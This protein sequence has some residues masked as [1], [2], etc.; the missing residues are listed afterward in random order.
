MKNCELIVIYSTYSCEKSAQKMA[1]LLLEKKLIAYANIIPGGSSLYMWE[2]KLCNE[3]ECFMLCK[4]TGN[5][6]SQVEKA[7][8][9]NHSYETP[10]IYALPTTDASQDYLDFVK[11]SLSK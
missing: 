3:Q 5:L 10:C 2:G 11:A 4:S 1:S 9:E 6:Y 8:V 7:I